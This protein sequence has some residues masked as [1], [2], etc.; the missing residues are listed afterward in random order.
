MA[1]SHFVKDS[2]NDESNLV[3]HPGSPHFQNNQ[4]FEYVH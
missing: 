3:S 2:S 1:N 4:K